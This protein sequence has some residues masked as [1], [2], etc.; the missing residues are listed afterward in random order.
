MEHLGKV[1]DGVY[2]THLPVAD[3]RRSIAFY[4][5]RLGL[6][7]ATE[8]MDRKV[9]FFWVGGK[10]S[11]MLGLWESGSG[12]LQMKLHFAFRASKGAVLAACETLRSAGIQPLGLRGE[13]VS[14]PVVLGWMPAISVYFNDPD[15]H[16]LEILSVLEE[17]SD[18]DFGVDSHSAWLA[19]HR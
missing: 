19:R 16:S 12:P 13:P 3:L 8:I 2:E 18:A 5:D 11:G 4:R 15:G 9:A 7:L 10:V 6:E 1:I 14:E 17:D